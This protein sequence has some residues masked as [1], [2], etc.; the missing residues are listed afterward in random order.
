MRPR[1]QML[2]LYSG[3]AT[4]V[5]AAVLAVMWESS[6][7]W[8]LYTI[9]A[10]AIWFLAVQAGFSAN[11]SELNALGAPMAVIRG[12]LTGLVLVSAFDV[13][14]EGVQ[15]H[16]LP[17]FAS[18]ALIFVLMLGWQTLFNRLLPCR[19]RVLIVGLGNIGQDIVRR[20]PLYRRPAFEVIGFVSDGRVL[21]DGVAAPILGEMG[22]LAEVIQTTRP[23]IVVIAL[24]QDRPA[25]F[26]TLLDNADAGFRIVEDAQ[27]CEHAFGWVPVRDLTRTW[28]VSVLHLYQ[29]PYSRISHRTFDLII[30][31]VGLI[32]VAPLLPFLFVAVKSSR[33]PLF[34]R[35][36][37]VGEYG[38]PFTL[39]KFRTMC[40]NAEEAGQ[41]IWAADRDPRITHAGRVMRRFRLDEIPQLWNVLRGEMSIVGPRPE[42]PEFMQMLEQNVPFWLRRQ[43]VKPGLTGWAQVCRGYTSDA[44]GSIDK[45][46]YDLWYIRH[47]SIFVDLAI[48]LQ[49]VRVVFT[50]R[51]IEPP[52]TALMQ[53]ESQ[54]PVESAAVQ[55]VS[56]PE[57]I[58]M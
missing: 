16:V 19:R 49:T 32:L 41:A 40:E 5:F 34:F 46:S 57:S 14:F 13:W 53:V 21:R 54:S 9:V 12:T 26:G 47:R 33:G 38:A 11:A 39:Y 18:A 25:V 28:F 48:C 1:R 2:I 22:E 50:G 4:L 30:A 42:R 8:R 37:R 36:I 35:Q 24:Q 56:P 3:R 45:L 23:D 51:S 52:R 27:F 55:P 10:S 43:L 7:D 58:A 6:S 17:L 20:I 44:E 15:M 29:Q 31:T